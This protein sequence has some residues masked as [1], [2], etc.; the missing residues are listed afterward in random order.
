MKREEIFIDQCVL[1]VYEC[2]NGTELEGCFTWQVPLTSSFNRIQDRVSVN[3]WDVLALD[4]RVVD[5][6]SKV[7]TRRTVVM[8][9]EFVLC[10]EGS[11]SV[12]HMILNTWTKCYPYSFL[13]LLLMMKVSRRVCGLMS[14]NTFFPVGKVLTV[15]LPMTMVDYLSRNTRRR[16][17]S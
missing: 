3:R 17:R 12:L 7:S 2:D 6:N 1:Y 13:V 10:T 4:D 15:Q 16:K 14:K 9:F 5:R 8:L 11:K